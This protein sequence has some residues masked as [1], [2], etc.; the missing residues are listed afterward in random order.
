M[1]ISDAC[2]SGHF[3]EL[4]CGLFCIHLGKVFLTK[5]PL[6]EYLDFDFQERR[7][8]MRTSEALSLLGYTVF[9]L[10]RFSWQRLLG[11]LEE[12]PHLDFQ[13]QRQRRWSSDSFDN[14]G[15]F[16]LLASALLC[17]HLGRASLVKTPLEEY[18]CMVFGLQ[19]C[20]QRTRS[21]DVVHNSGHFVLLTPGSFCI[22]LGK[23][24]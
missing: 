6:E 4:T 24:F 18:T 14:L 10:A 15:Q 7:Q 5:T 3:F 20:R 16:V 23:V 9:I 12:Y 19:E 21:S 2:Y 22:C 13:D 17:I 8:R 11:P 1:R